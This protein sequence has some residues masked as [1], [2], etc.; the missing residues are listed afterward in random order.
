MANS[1]SGIGGSTSSPQVDLLGTSAAIRQA[2]VGGPQGAS[3]ITSPAVEG[4]ATSLSNLGS[5][6]S[7]A[8]ALAAGQSSIRP[9]V[10][11]SLKSQIAAGT[12]KPDPNEVAARIA[13]ALKS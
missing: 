7:R 11:A 1:I 5:F 13:A 8:S 6:M 10:V 2:G 12:Y 3:E 4:D 9:D